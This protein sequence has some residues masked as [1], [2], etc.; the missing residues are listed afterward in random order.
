MKIGI[1]GTGNMGREIG[2]RLAQLGHSVFFGARRAEQSR[3]A[4]ALA[5]AALTGSNDEAAA[6]GQMLVWTMREADPAKV[7]TTP[8][9]LDGKIVVDLNN[10]D[11]A[12]EARTG[13][14]FERAIAE[15]LQ[16][17]APAARVVKAFNTIAME[18]FDT[19]P[20]ALRDAGAQ[21]FLAGGDTTAKS[22]V[23]SIAADLGLEAID[24]G[25][26]PAA[27]RAAEAMG[28]VIRLLMIDG[29]L[30]G[31][32]HLRVTRLPEPV[33]AAIGGRGPSEYR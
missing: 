4:A 21:T 25:Q 22:A 1:I 20:Q 13:A 6:F 10:R 27:F 3:A 23:A 8:S 31:R 33:L 5:P 12:R 2:V 17:S 32:A 11:Y 30:G 16:E 15:R 9:L 18:G 19:D 7:L 24:L 14:W 28:D 26:G 29:G